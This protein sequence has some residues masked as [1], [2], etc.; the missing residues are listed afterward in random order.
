MNL[1]GP[2]KSVSVRCYPKYLKEP[3]LGW[4]QGKGWFSMVVECWCLVGGYLCLAHRGH[5]L[6]LGW[7][8][9]MCKSWDD[10]K[11]TSMN[12]GSNCNLL[13]M[14]RV[15][16]EWSKKVTFKKWFFPF[17]LKRE[18]SPFEN[19]IF[20]QVFLTALFHLDQKHMSLSFLLLPRGSY[21][22]F[23]TTI[24]IFNSQNLYQLWELLLFC[25]SGEY[26]NRLVHGHWPCRI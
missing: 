14:R 11:A 17:P 7:L 22:T 6:E 1:Y 10:C 16:E 3:N 9:I 4:E 12:A 24:T 18:M 15:K 2:L 13:W 21:L 20:A 19:N 5:G 25:Y 8:G 23:P 26:R